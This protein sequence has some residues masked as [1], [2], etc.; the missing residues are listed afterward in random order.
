[1]TTGPLGFGGAADHHWAT[2]A[3]PTP[4]TTPPNQQTRARQHTPRQEMEADL[5]RC[6]HG[7]S[8]GTPCYL[9]PPP[10]TARWASRAKRK[11]SVPK[12]EISRP[13]NAD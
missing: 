3:D 1:M 7:A 11:V 13:E 10:V 9:P 2:A 8:P 5:G 12:S 4:P 6:L